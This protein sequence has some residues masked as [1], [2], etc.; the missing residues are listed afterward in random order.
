MGTVL[1][2]DIGGA[3]LKAATSDRRA[4]SV[5][6]ALWKHPDRLPAALAELAADFADCDEIAV[7]MTGELCD[8]FETKRDGVNCILNAV[9]NVSRSRPVWVWGTDGTWRHTEDAKNDYLTVA[10]A[11]WHATATFVGSRYVPTAAGLL[12]DIGS[13]T[14][15]IIPIVDWKP[16]ATGRTDPERL[17]SL[18]LVYTGVGRTPV[19]A[20]LGTGVA[21]ELFATSLDA[22]L[23][24]GQ[25]AESP[26]FTD[27]ADGRPA[28]ATHAHAR[29]SR[30]LCGDPVITDRV[31][32]ADLAA[33]IADRQL[34]LVR[35]A[36]RSVAVATFVRMKRRSSNAKLSV[37]VAGAGEFV[38]RKVI[39]ESTY[40][41]EEVESLSDRLG[42]V[43]S[44]CAPAYAVATL[45]AERRP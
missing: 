42:P 27:T 32:T 44:A 20:L 5:P 10:A 22:Y 13:T 31:A 26:E 28:T 14:T 18:E 8:C 16:A 3:N 21:A 43:L 23:L 17:N 25:V 29:L 35:Y 19:A 30:M 1:G 24:L 38:A 33:R 45:L 39:S 37:V 12:I 41:Q 11:N 34:E 15:D 2:L 9:R 36:V 7:T 6:F 4:R 40:F